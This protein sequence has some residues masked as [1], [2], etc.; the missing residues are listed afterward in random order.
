MAP[1]AAA[2]LSD[3]RAAARRIAGLAQRTPVATCATLDGMAG[4]R[5]FFK[6]EQWQKAGAFKFRGACNAVMLL[7]D[8]IAARGVV[9]HSSGN[10]A[11][12][13]ALAAR[14]RGI[15]AHI[16]MPSNAAAVKRRAVAS[17]GARLVECEPTLAAR[18]TTAAAV[19][20]DTG[21]T[22]IHPYD[23]P[24][25]IAGQGTVA[26]EFLEQVPELDAII[27][28]VGGGGL[29]AGICVAAKA[30]APAIRIFAAEPLG[31]D[32]AARSLAAGTLIPQTAPDTIADGLLTSLGQ[33]TWPIIRD[34]VECVITVSEAE[35]VAAMRQ[36]WE[37][38]KLLVE[39]SAA[40]AVAAALSPQFK[41]L[42]GIAR[43]GVVL[44]GGNADLDRLPW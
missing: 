15:P 10:H 33:L 39:P 23:H 40:V 14:Q 16:V 26:L 27:A 37:R 32:D 7:P 41:A 30:L 6:C 36:A 38:A 18:E 3:V 35:I 24:D 22:F 29:L 25:I 17:Y 31:A 8:A 34:Q 12:A 1:P 4:R 9:T 11:Q 5:L 42:A 19:Q 21:A 20:A 2:E 43:A 28:P 44:S 13:L